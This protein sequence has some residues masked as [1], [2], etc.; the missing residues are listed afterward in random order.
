MHLHLHLPLAF[1]SPVRGG[2]HA[3]PALPAPLHREPEQ[4]VLASVLAALSAGRPAVVTVR[5]RPG[6]GQNALARWAAARAEALGLRVLH[7]RASSAEGAL[8]HGVAAQLLA[9]LDGL[10]DESL[11]AL[12]APER[13]GRHP[14]LADLLGAARERATLLVV[15]DAQWLDQE[16]LSWLQAL[17]RRSRGVPL[18]L[19]AAGSGLSAGG[20]DWLSLAS[21]TCATSHELVLAP[22]SRCE[23]ART[24]E[25][26]CG[27]P[28]EAAFS[29]AA[30]RITAGNPAL[31]RDA[32][33]GFVDEGCRP[34]A[35]RVER[36][37]ATAAQVSAER[38][39]WALRAL[40]P[41]TLAT[42]RALAVCGH[43]LDLP[44]ACALAD[45][46][47]LGES[48]LR[49][50]LKATGIAVPTESGLR[51]D[52]VAR[53][54]VLEGMTVEERAAL[55]ARAAELAHRAAMDDRAVADLLL[56]TRPFGAPWA[57]L[58]LHRS[59]AAAIRRGDHRRAAGYLSR[60]LKEPLDP[61]QHAR[62]TFE[63]AAVQLV[64]APEAGHRL[65][66]ELVRSTGAHPELRLRAVDL[67]LTLGDPQC[68]RRAVADILPTARGSERDDLVALF[69][70]AEPTAA[71]DTELLSP[72]V[73][74]LSDSPASPA[75]AGVR[76]WQL[77]VRGTASATAREL[78]RRA[79]ARRAARSTPV[80]ARL[81]ACRA[82]CLTDDYE[83]A[84]AGLSALLTELRGDPL[85]VGAAQV[86]AVRAELYLRSGRLGAAEQDLGAAEQAPGRSDPTALH[87]RAVRIM[88]ALESGRLDVAR[89]LAATPTPRGIDDSTSGAYLLFARGL[90]ASS[91]GDPVG[92]GE[93]LR[94]CGRR[95]LSRQHVNPAV[96]PW[97]SMAALACQAAGE[98][99]EAVRLSHEELQ[100]ARHWGAASTVGW[101]ELTVGRMA[102]ERLEGAR[103]AVR[104]LRD[105]PVGLVYARA[106]AE[107]ASAELAGREGDRHAA[108]ASLARLST[109]TSTHPG[110]P[111]PERARLLAEE[112]G[113]AHAEEAPAPGASAWAALPQTERHTAALA[114][115]GHS[116]QHI[117]DM[118]SVSRRTVELRLSR[119][120]KKLRIGGRQELSAL[121]RAMEGH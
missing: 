27:E 54:R 111:M 20:P 97:R 35:E 43:L 41:R 92:A 118:L 49:A 67:G 39:L 9:P 75:Q 19:V 15:E 91:E 74:P 94:E 28:G 102:G 5:G 57:V 96:L 61:A 14:G 90:L 26:A 86:L 29:A 47:S 10:A 112:L 31:L 22:L 83:E 119:T 107:L 63:L 108:Q 106:L 95:L 56:C 71:D 101:A 32:L 79:L 44:M 80:R 115:N 23:V 2:P 18:A 120:Y 37:R 62:M 40:C 68:I 55:H 51:V 85:S 69:W 52:P 33:R 53:T 109:L 46:T 1:N 76:A 13:G 105:G 64:T 114:G 6:F 110:G 121:V 89:A 88:L 104:T 17:V 3:R 84:E 11:R 82:L 34:V 65:L 77:A 93:L 60:T 73:P 70:S 25:L 12:A 16:S 21:A 50:E 72:E 58:A 100:C 87:L 99:A 59:A 4:A 30:W 98:H 36:L 38:V 66:D 42:V 113:Q 8:R 24:V 117:A 78:A 103:R 7:A 48:R 116:N 45:S 81:A